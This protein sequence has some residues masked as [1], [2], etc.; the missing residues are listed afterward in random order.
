MVK[1]K[2]RTAV[3]PRGIRMIDL[4]KGCAF[5]RREKLT[6]IFVAKEKHITVVAVCGEI[7]QLPIFDME[8]EIAVVVGS[9]VVGFEGDNVTELYKPLNFILNLLAV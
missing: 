5:F 1:E 4:S 9:V 7:F 2:Y 6:D 3:K 8:R